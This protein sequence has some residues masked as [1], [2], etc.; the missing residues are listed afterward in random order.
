MNG[1]MMTKID[2]EY[3]NPQPPC[4]ERRCMKDVRP[5][6]ATLLRFCAIGLSLLLRINYSIRMD[7]VIAMKIIG[8]VPRFGRHT[9]TYTRPRT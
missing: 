5:R 4:D 9:H 7:V 6:A 2:E 1:K 8:N 3:R